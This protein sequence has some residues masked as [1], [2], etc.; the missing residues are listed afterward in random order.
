MH[1]IAF[2][3][4]IFWRFVNEVLEFDRFAADY[5]LHDVLL[6]V[7]A[8]ATDAELVA[9]LFGEQQTQVGVSGVGFLALH[10]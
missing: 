3:K 1:F 9:A 5:A 10:A 6:F 4:L 7:G 8:V 2:P